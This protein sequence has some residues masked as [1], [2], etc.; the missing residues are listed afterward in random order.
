MTSS[1]TL[2]S[3]LLRV[4]PVGIFHQNDEN[5][6]CSGAVPFM[7][8]ECHNLGQAEFQLNIG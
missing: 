5:N 7:N 2:K 4:N 1:L 6:I 3:E 8:K